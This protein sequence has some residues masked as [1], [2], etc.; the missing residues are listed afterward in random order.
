MTRERFGELDVLA[1]DYLLGNL[2]QAE[3]EAVEARIKADRRLADK[4]IEW[5]VRLTLSGDCELDVEPPAEVFARIEDEL[6]RQQT[7]GA[8]LLVTVRADEGPW[9]PFAP[10]ARKKPLYLDEA[11]A[12]EAFLLELQPGC[13]LPGHD[14]AETEDCLVLS[15]DFWIGDLRLGPGDF[16]AAFATSRHASCRTETGCRLFIKT[17]VA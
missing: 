1:A 4:I 15:G 12:T 6:D 5:Q 14:H 8:D 10:G 11:S 9:V 13:S 7:F 16:H 17:A 3:R 2:K